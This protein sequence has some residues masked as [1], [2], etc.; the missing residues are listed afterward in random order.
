ML[1]LLFISVHGTPEFF[2]GTYKFKYYHFLVGS[3][4]NEHLVLVQTPN[5]KPQ[6]PNPKPQTLNPKPEIPNLKP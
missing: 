4:E 1:V 2:E 3:K 5:P 6:T